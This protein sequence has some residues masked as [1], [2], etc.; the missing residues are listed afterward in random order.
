MR[1]AAPLLN[2]MSI[3]AFVRERRAA[4]GKSSF[5]CIGNESGDLDSLASAI[6][7]AY[8]MSLVDPYGPQIVP[9]LQTRRADLR[10]RMEN[11][12]ALKRAGIDAND[13]VCLDDVSHAP[14]S[15]GG[16]ALVDHNEP[17]GPFVSAEVIAIIDHHVDAHKYMH[18]APRIVC[19]PDEAASCSS[20]LTDYFR[21]QLPAAIP[22]DAA[23]LLLS[24][25]EIDTLHF[26]A[27]AKRAQ[28]ADYTA[29]DCL[30][31]ESSFAGNTSALDA[32]C[33]EL[34][35]A[36]NDVSHLSTQELLR[37]DYKAFESSTWRVGVAS[38]PIS[39][40]DFES[41]GGAAFIDDFGVYAAEKKLDVL[42]TLS[43][44]R[45]EQGHAR[46][47]LLLF[48]PPSAVRHGAERISAALA[49]FTDH[50]VDLQELP[51][52]CSAQGVDTQGRLTVAWTQRDESATRK[53]FAPA[54]QAICASVTKQTR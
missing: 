36:K 51:L 6:A 44:F 32:Y 23:D 28:R 31:P 22:K 2:A 1:A 7:Y 30:I 33:D 18:C 4:A 53:Q 17:T 10:L 11:L 37:R 9:V 43:G 29:R 46:R 27:D 41:R 40:E 47:Q 12:L 45:D 14:M 50:R 42:V 52:P 25:M 38:I 54:L 34:L 24:A 13:I 8:L 49:A 26:S 20:V 15:E 48:A 5:W 3:G 19:N 16:V 35:S 21:A 39:L